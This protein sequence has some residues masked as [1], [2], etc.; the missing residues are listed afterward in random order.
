MNKKLKATHQGEL[1]ISNFKIKCAVLE[2]GSRILVERSVANALG[3]K[4]AGAYWEKKKKNEG[5][6]ILPEYIS[7]KYLE[8]FVSDELKEKLSEPIEYFA[9][10]SKNAQGRE[11]TILPDI[12][13]VWIKAKE[14]GALSKSQEKIAQNA[15]VLMRGFANIGIIAL[16]DEATGYQEIRDKIALQ[17]ILDK[18]LLKEHA[19]WAKRFPDE[20]YQKLFELK[21]WQW[22]GIRVKRPGVVGIY[23]NDLVYSRLAQ[24]ILAELKRLNPPNETTGRRKIKHHQWLTND[25]GH[26]ALQQ[27]IHALIAFMRAA[28]NWGQFHRMV[29]RAFPK[30]GETIPMQF[31]DEEEVN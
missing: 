5:G 9:L 16:V 22:E 23:T 18:Y 31:P 2:N 10:N 12:C 7:A 21:G 3:I 26:P 27:H 11:A 30:I 13:D 24:G 4:G 15:Y 29:E 14:A 6:I 8:P 20:F 25:I 19:K 28:A 17:K 1:S